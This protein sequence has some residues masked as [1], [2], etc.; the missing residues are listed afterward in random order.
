MGRPNPLMV[1]RPF[2]AII[3]PS[4]SNPSQWL[5]QLALS[6]VITPQIN[7]AGHKRQ[8][9]NH[10]SSCCF[11]RAK[12]REMDDYERSQEWG[13]CSSPTCRVEYKITHGTRGH[14]CLY[15]M[16]ESSLAAA[17]PKEPCEDYERSQ[18]WSICSSSP[19]RVECTINHGT[20]GYACLYFMPEMITIQYKSML[21]IYQRKRKQKDK[22]TKC[23]SS[24]FN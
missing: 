16:P 22:I 19:Y 4:L 10:T 9:S 15:Y 24:S 1:N 11:A 3:H 20:R 21:M 14:A 13:V 17:I 23:Y 7:V 5:H 6:L 18:E 12:T 2:H 8:E